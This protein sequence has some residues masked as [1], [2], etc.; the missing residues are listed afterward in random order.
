MQVTSGLNR[1]Q[2]MGYDRSHYQQEMARARASQAQMYPGVYNNGPQRVAGSVASGSAADLRNV[3]QKA[4]D[5]QKQYV[6]QVS[7]QF[8]SH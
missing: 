4:Q 5:L 3:A 1:Q 8:Y 6:Q 7:S 2:P